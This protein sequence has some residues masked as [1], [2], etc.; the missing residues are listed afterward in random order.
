MAVT[1]HLVLEAQDRTKLINNV[2]YLLESANK[3]QSQA[4]SLFTMLVNDTD[5]CDYEDMA[6]LVQGQLYTARD[7]ALEASAQLAV[8]M[9]LV[10]DDGTNIYPNWITRFKWEI[11][12]GGIQSI[13]FTASTDTIQCFADIAA[14]QAITN[15]HSN[16]DQAINAHG[17]L[18]GAG[19]LVIV[20]GATT[21]ANNG[22]KTV[23]T[24]TSSNFT[25]SENLTDETCVTAGAYVLLVRQALGV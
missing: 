5:Y 7:V 20:S 4:E 6:G 14:T 16:G 10:N 3:A 24:C 1:N 22:I 13:K 21:A 8:L 19:D 12:K 25:V 2:I 9:T 15:L 11:G 23:A 18:L 17:Y